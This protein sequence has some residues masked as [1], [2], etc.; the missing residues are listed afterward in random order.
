MWWAARRA[1][2]VRVGELMQPG[3]DGGLAR[4]VHGGGGEAT[5]I[6]C[7]FLASDQHRNPLI[8]TLPRVL[9]IDMVQAGSSEWIE[10]SLSFAI[11][12]LQEGRVGASAVMS[13]LSELMFVEAV[14]GYAATLSPEQ[15]G[16]L[17]GMRDLVSGARS[18]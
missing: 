14:R 12:G 9:K 7:G 17:A 3:E 11:K 6:V 18:R 8:A 4:I 15:K 13:R 16:W 1:R 10:S 5:N 2:P